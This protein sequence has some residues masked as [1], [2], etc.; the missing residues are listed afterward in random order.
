MTLE[1]SAEF[2]KD[3]PKLNRVLAM[4]C[5]LG[6]GYVK[7]GQPST[8]LSGGEAQRIKLATELGKR[9]TGRTLYVLDEPTT[10]LHFEDIRK[11]LS[12]LHSLVEAGNSVIVIEHNLDVILSA[13]HL[14]ELGPGGG[15]KGGHIIAQGT[16]ESVADMDTPTGLELK[17]FLDRQKKRA[18]GYYL[19]GNRKQLVDSILQ[20]GNGKKSGSDEPL[21]NEKAKFEI[22]TWSSAPKLI[23]M[24]DAGRIV[25][26]GVRK[27]NL[28]NVSLDLPKNKIITVTGLS[29]SGKT[30]L[31]FETLF[32]EG[33]RK[34]IES[35]S[36]YA[37]RFLGR[38]PR[39]EADLIQGISPTI[40]VDQK[41]G[42]R[43]P[44]STLATT[45]EIHDSFRVLFANI[46]KQHCPDCGKPVAK[47]GPSEV[48]KILENECSGETCLFLAPLFDSQ[49]SRR[50]ILESADKLVSYLPVLQEKGYLRIWIDGKIYRLDEEGLAEKLSVLVGATENAP[51]K[52]KGIFS[53]KKKKE[54]ETEKKS[55]IKRIFLV[56][57]R[58]EVTD[59]TR[60]RIIEIT[61]KSYEIGEDILAVLD[62]K[63]NLRFFAGHPACFDHD[64][65]FTDVLSPR[66]FS[67]NHHLGACARCQGI[68]LA[69]AFNE[70]KFIADEE[71]PLLRGAIYK[72]ISPFFT[73][74][75][76][77]YGAS[78]KSAA[79][80]ANIDV[81][82]MPW[83]LLDYYQ[84]IFILR[85]SKAAAGV[86]VE[87]EPYAQKEWKGIAA[88]IE[89]LYT[90]SESER[91]G[92]AFAHLIDF[93]TCPE[94]G[95][96]RL[97]KALLA[98]K[99][100]GKSIHDISKMNAREAS[101]FFKSL[102]KNL[103]ARERKMAKE[104]LEE[105]EFRLTHLLYLGLHYLS[106][107]R[108]MGTL[109]G[110]E[111]QRVRLSTQ[112]G[113]KLKDVIYVLDEPTIGLHERETEQ[114]LEAI[115]SLRDRGNTVVMV[116]H[117]GRVIR[118]SDWIVDIGPGAGAKGGELRYSGPWD[119]ANAAMQGASFFK[120]LST[121][122]GRA[123]TTTYRTRRSGFD[124]KKDSSLL[125]SG[126]KENNL[127]EI[128][129][130]I[131]LG[132]LTAL[133]GVSGSGKSSLMNWFY[134]RVKE[135]SE[136]GKFRASS[137]IALIEK[138]K[139]ST[140]NPFTRVDYVDQSPVSTSQRSTSASYMDIY[141]L[142]RDVFA[143]CREA[144]ARG[145]ER[146][147]FSFNSAKGQCPQ[148][149]GAGVEEIEMHFISDVTVVCESCKG[150]RYRREVLEVF[151]KGKNI[152]EILNLTYR[153]AWDFFDGLEKI[154]EKIQ[155]LLDAGL[156][157][158]KL[159]MNTNILSGGELQRL[160]IARELS[161]AKDTGGNLY[162]LDEP[163]TGLHFADTE[164]LV[165]TLDRLVKRGNT[166]VVIEHNR[167]FLQNCDYLIDL[168]P[169]GGAEGGQ[170]VAGGTPEE[171]KAAKKGYTW[172]YL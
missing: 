50:F 90:R 169:E 119:E 39:A 5:E 109:S 161:T 27:H 53:F 133:S 48:A 55:E 44:R 147:H 160:K 52:S 134:P 89:D 45:T 143:K 116:E 148:C 125:L 153:E 77:F 10:G 80:R 79:R 168:G 8:T 21:K 101:D 151:Y 11:L 65:H 61:E 15:G 60:S 71:S 127:K 132:S 49:S 162:L 76:Q 108:T 97:S 66:H 87:Y 113:N 152:A 115:E 166:V 28:K 84:K 112:I 138:G 105:I 23:P 140:Q 100:E 122:K 51:E 20:N 159:G 96:G 4:L 123:P 103:P 142:I 41:A 17:S 150:A 106:L 88:I 31:A 102:D 63:A 131:P 118:T 12:A 165:K 158:L 95:G 144:K 9:A 16:P 3:I 120:Y 70:K 7:L 29:G 40:A 81:W 42:S 117:D 13:D 130:R 85:G 129:V 58:F 6:M 14:M 92:P 62:G 69:R 156:G 164:L 47:E 72:G 157:Y 154:R 149:Q 73:R 93:H 111:S 75:G 35:L 54:A 68:G 155:F 1:E 37:R 22:D 2:F 46:G 114:L 146:G 110:G 83:R 78:L 99:I 43:N 64:F 38:I 26:R 94:C 56:L 124:W 18:K 139:A 128:E 170:L 74:R 98:V 86:K 57:D 163:T 91:F 19:K 24:F 121:D 104:V 172:K 141:D 33:Q 36:T 34:Y 25:L 145:Y 135:A 171:I 136:K 126:L 82:T 30:S 137:G 67:F 32:Q 107:D 167:E 59:K